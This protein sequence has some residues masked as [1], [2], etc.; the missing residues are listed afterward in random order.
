MSK[1]MSYNDFYQMCG[2][3]PDLTNELIGSGAIKTYYKNGVMMID[4][5]SAVA[6]CSTLSTGVWAI[7]GGTGA[8]YSPCPKEW[9]AV[10]QDDSSIDFCHHV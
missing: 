4:Y 8:P 2:A 1:L 9:R 10:I 7:R 5:D 6:Y 3:L